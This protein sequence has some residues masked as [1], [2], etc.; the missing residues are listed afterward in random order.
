MTKTYQIKINQGKDAK[1]LDIPQAGSKGQAVTVK[2]VSGARYQLIDPETGFGPENIRASRQGKDLKV[3]FE[4]SKTTDLVIEDYYTVTADNF[5]GLIGEAESGKFYEYIPE[6]A[7]GMASVP[8]LADAGQVVGMALGGAEVAPAGAAVGVLAAGLFSPWLLGAGALGL[9]AA[10]GG[11]GGGAAATTDTTAPTGQTGALSQVSTSDSG[12]LGDNLTGITKPVITGK[13]EAGSTVE[14]SFRDPAGKLTGPYKT[15]ADANGN[16]SL[17]VPNSLVDAST[18]T[19]GTQYTP[20]IKATDAAG[21]SSTADGTSFVVDTQAPSVAV[22]ID[23]D[24]NND[25]Y[26]NAAEKG[27]AI[28]TSV[29]VILDKSKMVAGDVIALTNATNTKTETVTLT[30]ADIKAGQIVSKGWELP[31]EGKQLT[32]MATAQDLAGNVSAVASDVAKLDLTAPLNNKGIVSLTI[33]LDTNNDASINAAEMGGSKSTVLTAKFDT[34]NLIAGDIITF[35]D[36]STTKPVTLTSKAITD[37]QI[38]TDWPLPPEGSTLKVNAI[39]SDAAGNPVPQQLATDSAKID[40]L[41]PSG[42]TGWLAQK[43]DTG[44]LDSDSITYDDTPTIEGAAESNAKIE[45]FLK[46]VATG[47]FVMDGSSKLSYVTTADSNGRYSIDVT[48]ILPDNSS[49]GHGT[50]YFPIIK[51]TDGS[52][53]S[54]E[55]D[56]VAFTIDKHILFNVGATEVNS[57]GST[58]FSV[59]PMEDLTFKSGNWDAASSSYVYSSKTAVISGVLFEKT[60]SGAPAS[61][62]YVLWDIAGNWLTEDSKFPGTTVIDNVHFIA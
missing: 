62:T 36:G 21:N 26:I 52:Q 40:T 45:V 48:K 3:S 8:M 4:G 14:V 55:K 60:L 54:S 51:V 23:A 24:A 43:S 15:T 30:D 22:Q 49:N 2:A 61:N 38:T 59:N 44:I 17:Q 12:K 53:N 37:G 5:N 58:K 6:N 46:D 34:T 35:S 50:V 18:D 16:Y 1:A 47:Q 33:D 41:V 27:T 28:T 42:Q 19:K 29:T 10:G 25:G 13:A 32:V 39:L 11:G 31:D 9:A 7:S 56:G 57:A 20:V